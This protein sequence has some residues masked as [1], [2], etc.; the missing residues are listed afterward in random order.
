MLPDPEDVEADLVGELGFLD[1]VPHPLTRADH[2]AV[3]RIFLQFRERVDPDLHRGLNPS[4]TG[5][6]PDA[7]SSSRQGGDPRHP[8]FTE[9]GSRRE[10]SVELQDRHPVRE[11]PRGACA[12]LA[13]GCEHERRRGPGLETVGQ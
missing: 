2:V 7:R 8:R 5:G 3:V 11:G 4:R 13:A 12:V 6:V 10:P 1:Q 9:V